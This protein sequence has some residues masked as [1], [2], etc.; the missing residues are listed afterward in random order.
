MIQRTPIG[1]NN[2]DLLLEGGF[3]KESNILLIGAPGTGKTIFGLEYLYNGATK[4]EENGLF[5]SL[6]QNEKN[7][8]EQ[9]K[10]LGFDFETLI[11]E[12]KIKIQYF[13]VDKITKNFGEEIKKAVKEINAK[14]LVFD[15][16][17]LL[18]LNTNFLQEKKFSLIRGNELKT[19]FNKPQFVYNFIHILEEINTTTLIIK[20]YE[21][22]DKELETIS[23]FVCDGVICLKSTPMGKISVRTIEIKKMR[24]T[25]CKCGI[26]SLKICKGIMVN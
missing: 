19:S 22:A 7:L 5:I 3:P 16:L 24:K 2:L 12:K 17:S 14:R 10:C 15:S 4:Y 23:E 6:E 20:N 21:S 8:K 18:L 11:K 26:Y 9:A 1:I 25:D 13:P